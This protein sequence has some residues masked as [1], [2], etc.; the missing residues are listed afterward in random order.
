MSY[1]RGTI[2]LMINRFS[3]SASILLAPGMGM[4]MFA[5]VA[6]GAAIHPR[7]YCDHFDTVGQNYR[8]SFPTISQIFEYWPYAAPLLV[9]IGISNLFIAV[10]LKCSISENKY[11]TTPL[12]AYL[13]MLSMWGVVGTSMRGHVTWIKYLHAAFTALL[14]FNSFT[15]LWYSVNTQQSRTF[16]QQNILIILSMV[17]LC[18]C[19]ISGILG[20][21]FVNGS[22]AYYI[23]YQCLAVGELSYIFTFSTCMHMALTFDTGHLT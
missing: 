23:A 3:A 8:V 4:L 6:S 19:V 11:Y 2:I 12:M 21:F 5:F 22:H 14:F 7:V 15:L 9:G 16:S 1:N 13:S 10:I 18:V 20:P 17:S